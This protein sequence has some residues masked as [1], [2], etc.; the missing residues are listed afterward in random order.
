MQTL[1]TKQIKWFS[2]QQERFK[3]PIIDADV[4]DNL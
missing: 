1:R 2:S 3:R 4:V